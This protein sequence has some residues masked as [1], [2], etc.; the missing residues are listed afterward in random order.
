MRIV[1]S[2]D[3]QKHLFEILRELE[4]DGQPIQI[5]YKGKPLATLISTAEFLGERFMY[6]KT[7]PWKPD[8][9]RQWQREKLPA[10]VAALEKSDAELMR[11]EIA[12]RNLS[13]EFARAVEQALAR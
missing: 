6:S 13:P 2:K 3:L 8:E 9:L 12:R 7:A 10:E 11:K 4:R 1:K 5:I